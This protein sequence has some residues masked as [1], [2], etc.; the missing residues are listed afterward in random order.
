[1]GPNTRM[2]EL[3]LRGKKEG[4]THE[5]EPT[6]LMA[7]ETLVT[8]VMIAVNWDAYTPT[9]PNEESLHWPRHCTCLHSVSAVRGGIDSII[10]TT[11]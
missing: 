7:Y 9:S 1:M 11:H 3:A 10:C 8:A 4:S 2:D 5:N 6:A